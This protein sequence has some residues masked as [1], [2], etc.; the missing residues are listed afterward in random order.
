[1]CSRL[2]STQTHPCCSISKMKQ[3]F[4]IEAVGLGLERL[5]FTLEGV[6]RSRMIRERRRA[7]YIR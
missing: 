4:F 6:E 7:S 5:P 3:C 2:G 1:M